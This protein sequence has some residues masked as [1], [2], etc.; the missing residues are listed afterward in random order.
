VSAR[1]VVHP[2]GDT[3]APLTPRF[4]RAEDIQQYGTGLYNDH[5]LVLL[6]LPGAS[7]S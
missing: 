3:P 6:T 7:K 5:D 1:A 4:A 2:A